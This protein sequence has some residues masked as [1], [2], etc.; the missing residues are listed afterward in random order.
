ML[1]WL[2]WNGVKNSEFNLQRDEE[3]KILTLQNTAQSRR[4]LYSSLPSR[5][6]PQANRVRRPVSLFSWSQVS[7]LWCWICL[8]GSDPSAINW[9]WYVTGMPSHKSLLYTSIFLHVNL[10]MG[11]LPVAS[12]LMDI[13]SPSI[14]VK[15]PGLE[16]KSGGTEKVFMR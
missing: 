3:S 15:F 5:W 16:L 11:G 14:T 2:S 13:S 1:R 4:P 6:K 9:Q 8:R 7:R 10:L 12:I